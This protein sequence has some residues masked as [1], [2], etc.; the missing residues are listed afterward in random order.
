MVRKQGM[1]RKQM[2]KELKAMKS[3]TLKHFYKH[4]T[5]LG[6]PHQDAKPRPWGSTNKIKAIT[7]PP[8]KTRKKKK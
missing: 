6:K 4:D 8:R 3:G 2:Q 5:M 7:I 1:T